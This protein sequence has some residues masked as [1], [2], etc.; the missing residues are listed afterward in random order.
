MNGNP[1]D[2]SAEDSG[3]VYG[4][5]ISAITPDPWTDTGCALPGVFGDPQLLGMGSLS[6]ESSNSIDLS[7]SLP[8]VLAALFLATSSTPT[9][10]KGG[11]LKP[12]H[13]FTPIFL[14]TSASGMISIPFVMP[15]GIPVGTELWV[16]WGI[17]DAAAING[18]ALS[19]A[20]LGLTP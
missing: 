16:Q 15:S 14:N 2:N 13:F 1:A 17:Q 20:I 8:G 7:N 19:N 6:P 9:A 11:T 5:D 4:F 12:F 18:V 3:A 10:W